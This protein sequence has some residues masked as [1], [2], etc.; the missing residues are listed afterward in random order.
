VK[1]GGEKKE[2][3]NEKNVSE[4]DPPNREKKRAVSLPSGSDHNKSHIAPS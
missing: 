3:K 1:K 2:E 4:K